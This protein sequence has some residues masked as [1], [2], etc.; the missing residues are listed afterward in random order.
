M[1]IFEMKESSTLTHRV[2]LNSIYALQ[3]L[4][5]SICNV[6]QQQVS[7]IDAVRALSFKHTDLDDVTT[8]A[9]VYS[10]VTGS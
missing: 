10:L 9:R 7:V 6:I 4:L 5:L 1:T 8:D 2:S 3:S